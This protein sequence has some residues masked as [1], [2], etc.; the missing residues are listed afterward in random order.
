[1]VDVVTVQDAL[2]RLCGENDLRFHNKHLHGWGIVCGLR[3]T[4]G[5]DGEGERRANV[6]VHPG[7]ALDCEGNDIRLD[8]DATLDIM[9]MIAISRSAI[10]TIRCWTRTATAKSR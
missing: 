9:R 8:D 7:Y 6:T 5:P 3:V 10:P 1:M 4:C 2:E